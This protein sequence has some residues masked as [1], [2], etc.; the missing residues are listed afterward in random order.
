MPLI[1]TPMAR[2][3]INLHLEIYIDATERREPVRVERRYAARCE[4]YVVL[5]LST[6]CCQR[7]G[8]EEQNAQNA[9]KVFHCS[10]IMQQ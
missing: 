10:L 3:W 9:L 7:Y 4:F 5:H 2:L 1:G 8:H 6:S